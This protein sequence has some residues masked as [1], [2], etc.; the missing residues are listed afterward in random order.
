MP[1]ISIKHIEYWAPLKI[2]S[3]TVMSSQKSRSFTKS[4]LL[5]FAKNHIQACIKAKTRLTSLLYCP[6]CLIL[7]WT[8][9]FILVHIPNNHLKKLFFPTNVHNTLQPNGWYIWNI[10]LYIFTFCTAHG[11][12]VIYTNHESNNWHTVI[13]N[14]VSPGAHT[15]IYM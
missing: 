2:C 1:N 11:S 12:S 9:L 7:S 3:S 4:V 13:V 6:H 5:W 8:K 10:S 15:Y 14:A